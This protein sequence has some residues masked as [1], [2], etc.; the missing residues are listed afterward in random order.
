MWPSVTLAAQN[1]RLP[2][3]RSNR[4]R[5]DAA[6]NPRLQWTRFA[7]P[8]MRPVRRPFI[9]VPVTDIPHPQGWTLRFPFRITPSREITG[10][11]N[12]KA[13]PRGELTISFS[14]KDGRYVVK[15]SGLA[16]EEAARLFADRCWA[17]MMWV[18]IQKDIPFTVNMEFDNV[19]YADDP[20]EA[21]ANLSRS[22]GLK[23]D[24]PVHGLVNDGY[25]AIYQTAHSVKA[26]GLGDVTFLVSTPIDLFASDFLQGLSFPNAGEIR[27]NRKL[28]TA[29]DLYNSQAY[30][31]SYASRFLT[32]MIALEAVA[33]PPRKPPIAIDLLR[34]WQA[35]LHSLGDTL[36]QGSE[37]RTALESL[38]REL[39]IRK[40][41][42]IRSSIRELV[43]STFAA[44]GAEDAEEQAAAAVD[45]Y[46]LRSTLVHEGYLPAEQLNQAESKAKMLVRRILELKFRNLGGA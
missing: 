16:S 14:Q 23:V 12:D 22:L 13:Y 20:H 25:L 15:V 29:L 32:L 4:A 28:A 10:L 35:E 40:K 34:K 7:P 19:V 33:E 42:S 38:E 2:L 17:A 18:L 36:P 1:R 31:A 8:L 30:E 9:G 21:A 6:P 3:V 27:A 39:L 45:L 44:A 37:D 43:R 46:D 41:Q 24:G 11:A 26:I 5:S